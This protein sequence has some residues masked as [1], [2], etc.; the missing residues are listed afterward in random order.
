M[1]SPPRALIALSP[2]A[3]SALAPVSTMPISDS[4]NT[5]AALS[6]STSMD[7]TRIIDARIDRK[8]E[9]AI[10]LDEQMIS[11]R[12]QIRVP[13]QNGSLSS[14][15]FT[16]ILRNADSDIAPESHPSAIPMLHDGDGQRKG[17]RQGGKKHL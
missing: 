11:C 1:A 15:S 7:G 3:P 9:D 10:R 12:G 5:S 2:C 17:C 16:A 13:A 6:N 4:A 8:A 14:A